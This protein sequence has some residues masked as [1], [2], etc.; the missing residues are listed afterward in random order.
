VARRVEPFLVLAFLLATG[1]AGCSDGGGGDGLSAA[2]RAAREVD[3]HATQDTGV[4]RGVVVD[5]AIAPIANVTVRIATVNKTT[6]SNADGAFGFEALPPGEY[7]LD[8]S[9]DGYT[10]VQG[11]AT[12]V[13]GQQDPDVVKLLLQVVPRADP[14][15][16][17]IQAQL[18]MDSS[19]AVMGSSLTLGGFTG[20]G[21]Y[22]LAADIG[23]NATVVQVEYRWE[24]TLPTGD[25]INSY[26]GTYAGDDRVHYQSVTG[27]SP[28]VARFNATDGKAIADRLSLVIRADPTVPASVFANQGVQAYAHIFYN[29]MPR[30]DWQF[31]RDGEYPVPTP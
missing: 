29:F 8:A 16:V 27:G 4:I 18:F 1:L 25:H 22:G 10:S 3:V 7:F 6:T 26:G 20:Q 14:Y 24:P 15:V 19:T 5:S 13:A 11:H 9:R 2:E 12:V 21:S 31:G 30:E 28:L 17:P 23:P